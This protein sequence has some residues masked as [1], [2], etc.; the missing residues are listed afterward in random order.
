[1]FI[2]DVW[3]DV[4]VPGLYKVCLSIDNVI[5]SFINTIYQIFLLL[6]NAVLVDSETLNQLTERIYQII[7]VVMLFILAY[8]LLRALV[9]PDE[10]NKGEQSAL[11]FIFNI[12]LSIVLIVIMPVI[13]DF[14]YKLQ[15]ALLT[16]N[17]IGK[18]IIGTDGDSQ[19]TIKNGGLN[20]SLSI[21]QAFFHP[22]GGQDRNYCITLEQEIEKDTYDCEPLTVKDDNNNDL[23][24]GTVVYEIKNTAANFIPFKNFVL[25]I[26]DGT[27]TY[28]FLISSIAGLF[29][30]YILVVYCFDLGLRAVKLSFYQLISPVAVL[31]RLMPGESNKIFD[32]WVKVTLATFMEVFIRIAIL[33][34]AVLL[35]D[36]VITKF[37]TLEGLEAVFATDAG[38]VSGSVMFF[39]KAFIIMGILTFVKQ[40]PK[41]ISDL[42]GID[43]GN[44]S[45][46]IK[47]RL[48]GMLGAGIVGG[49][50]GRVA[51]GATG[52]VGA[53]LAA[54]R[55]GGSFFAGGANGFVNG[56]KAKGNQFG[57]QKQAM[58]KR[59]GGTGRAG[60]FGKRSW[61]DSGVDK[62]Q[63][64]YKD[65]VK[66][67]A[68]KRAESFESGSKFNNAL[69]HAY[70]TKHGLSIEQLRQADS[71][72][73]TGLNA[74]LDKI[75][76]TKHQAA[77]DY[78]NKKLKLMEENADFRRYANKASVEM[79]KKSSY[80]D[81]T[82][83]VTERKADFEKFR[84]LE[85]TR[86]ALFRG[87]AA[88][89]GQNALFV[90]DA[91]KKRDAAQ[92]ELTSSESRK[93]LLQKQKSYVEARA[94]SEVDT[95]M[96]DQVRTEFVKDDKAK[97]KARQYKEDVERASSMQK[98]ADQAKADADLKKLLDR[99]YKESDKKKDKKE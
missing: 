80:Y 30:V 45:L 61:V 26:V 89:N 37:E 92:L 91:L 90:K 12:V 25:N 75:D 35:L 11:K 9:N 58:Y 24:Y 8:S 82:K 4:I 43:S 51:G 96:R 17:T 88:S 36:V 53:G 98:Q 32:K 19:S 31:S 50:I 47:N 46:G 13:F 86:E 95:L 28:N 83:S 55:A 34:F 40:A 60:I 27:I 6:S 67:G 21:F 87:Y 57:K 93:S 41:L 81:S 33:F 20:M 14:A 3:T 39:A 54:K 7:S 70:A 5:Y 56:W 85:S 74:E 18:I 71:L 94:S 2:L 78:E 84:K 15:G 16:N 1:M 38:A 73:V 48:S 59:L 44:M 23:T 69:E 97:G 68:A 10:L 66:K 64:K 42:T 52:F 72:G 22:T 76:T 77:I 49:A 65:S 29:V 62:L 63:N 99:L 79:F